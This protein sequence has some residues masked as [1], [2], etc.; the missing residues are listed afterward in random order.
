MAAILEKYSFDS[1]SYYY[2][3]HPIIPILTISNRNR[4]RP[5]QGH[6]DT[7]P[8]YRSD[9]AMAE[10]FKESLALTIFVR[11]KGRLCNRNR[12]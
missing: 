2:Y 11:R 6:T 5:F 7:H 12:F 4:V 1:I 8:H 9:P 3:S 10:I